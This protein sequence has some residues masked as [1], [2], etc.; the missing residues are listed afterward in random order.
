MGWLQNF[1]NDLIKFKNVYNE[2]KITTIAENRHFN[3]S[4]IKKIDENDE[5]LIIEDFSNF[6]YVFKKSNIVSID[7]YAII[8]DKTQTPL[9]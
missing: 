9:W 5:Y 4:F 6:Y 2:I 1:I 8:H 7:L 3:T